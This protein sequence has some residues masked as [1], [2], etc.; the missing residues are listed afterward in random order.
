MIFIVFTYGYSS[1]Q[2]FSVSSFFIYYALLILAPINYVVWKLVKR[3]KT[4]PLREVD[5]IWEAPVIDAYEA[6]F[7]EPP[8]GFW[9]EML[10]LFGI[11]RKGRRDRRRSSVVSNI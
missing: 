3:T 8:N 2:P 4:V 11:K 10:Q 7:Y 1:F 6:T 5:L 9:M